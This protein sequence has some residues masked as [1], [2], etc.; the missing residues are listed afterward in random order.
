MVTIDGTGNRLGAI[1]YGPGNVL[2]IAGMNKVCDTL[3]EAMET[4]KKK[5]IP[6]LISFV[7]GGKKKMEVQA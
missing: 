5:G 6:A 2:V 4:A 3:D 1:V 7:G